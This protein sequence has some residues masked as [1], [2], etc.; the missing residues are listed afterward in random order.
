MD[1]SFAAAAE[2]ARQV[3]FVEANR[4]TACVR[5]GERGDLNKRGHCF[6]CSEKRLASMGT[7]APVTGNTVPPNESPE[8]CNAR[9]RNAKAERET[10][11]PA[12]TIYTLLQGDGHPTVEGADLNHCDAAMSGRA[13]LAGAMANLGSLENYIASNPAN[14]EAAWRNY[15]AIYARCAELARVVKEHEAA[16]KANHPELV[17]E[18][19]RMPKQVERTA[20]REWM[21]I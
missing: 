11:K 20:P 10:R 13:S 15:N 7:D 18:P 4:A 14:A 2:S 19:L 3:A 5:C 9:L 17:T 8:A 6:K 1:T 12:V 16:V 21:N